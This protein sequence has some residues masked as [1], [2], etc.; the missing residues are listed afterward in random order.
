MGFDLSQ[1][2]ILVEG[3]GIFLLEARTGSE[4]ATVIIGLLVGQ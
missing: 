3:L 4:T 2:G 1:R